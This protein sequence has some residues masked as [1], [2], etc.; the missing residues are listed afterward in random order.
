[1]QVDAVQQRPADL[2]EVALDDAA[3]AAAFVRRI[4]KVTA[5]TPVQ[6][7]TDLEHEPRVPAAGA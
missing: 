3:G 6:I 4:A 5:R 2:A 7:S 1:M